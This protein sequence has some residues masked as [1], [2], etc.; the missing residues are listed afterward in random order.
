MSGLVS[1]ASRN[2]DEGG[3]VLLSRAGQ[4]D[5]VGHPGRRRQQL[6]Q[7]GADPGGE[8]R[9]RQPGR[10]DHVGGHARVPAAVGDHA[11]PVHGMGAIAEQ[12]GRGV[13]ELAGAGDAMD[14]S[15]VAGRVDDGAVGGER[16]GVR[17]R[18][19]DRRLAA[20]DGEQQHRLACVGR[21]G[22]R[23]D[24]GAAVAE[25]LAVDGDEIGVGV[26]DAGLDEVGHTQIGL[27]AEGDEAG[28]SVPTRCEEAA[29]LQ[30]HVPALR[31][32]RNPPGRQG[33]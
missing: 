15:G 6:A 25:V 13:R 24:E 28:E 9:H 31:Q 7:C 12:R 16:A 8:L 2:G 5:G 1:T 22:R 11:H 23:R 33:I 3:D 32:Q 26:F 14:A 4:V 27:V 18:P 30:C 10:F 17:L 29:Q 20:A 19:A 21:C